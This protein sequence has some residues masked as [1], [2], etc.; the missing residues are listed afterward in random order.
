MKYLTLSA[1]LAL[2]GA[3][4]LAPTLPAFGLQQRS[5]ASNIH[6]L[7]QYNRDARDKN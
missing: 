6:E 1:S 7:V 5:S 4:A 2:I 3:I